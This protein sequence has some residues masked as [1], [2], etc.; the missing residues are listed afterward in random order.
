[1]THCGHPRC[2]YCDR[3]LL[4]RRRTSRSP[5]ASTAPTRD[6]VIPKCH[7]LF[8]GDQNNVVIACARCNEARG[9]APA[10]LFLLFARDEL[11]AAPQGSV[12]IVAM[13]FREWL[14]SNC[15]MGRVKIAA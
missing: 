1:M 9:D 15:R 6:H 7:P 14:R 10:I 12:R 8:P 4:R 11:Q 5:W 3:P 2:F 13:R